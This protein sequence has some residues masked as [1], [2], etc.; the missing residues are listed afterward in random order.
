VDGG[1]SV[2]Q[3]DLAKVVNMKLILASIE[4]LSI[5]KINFYKSKIFCFQEAKEE[6]NAYIIN[7]GC[8]VGSLSFKYL[9]FAIH[10]RRLLNKE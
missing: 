1:K 6:H 2:L 3:H 5:L 10:Y 7:F 9:G 8:E 4:Q